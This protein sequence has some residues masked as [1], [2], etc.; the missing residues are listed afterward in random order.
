[1]RI[2]AVSPNECTPR[3][4]LSSLVTHTHTH[5]HS[6]IAPR[7]VAKAVKKRWIYEQRRL[8]CLNPERTH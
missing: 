4:R 1:M 2:S 7:T 6:V 8:G 3:T 5:T